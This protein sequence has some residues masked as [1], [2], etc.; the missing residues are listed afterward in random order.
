M[1][2]YFRNTQCENTS[3]IFCNYGSSVI[4]WGVPVC[5]L[6]IYADTGLKLQSTVQCQYPCQ[7]ISNSQDKKL[8]PP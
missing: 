8:V 4:Q 7:C 2:L 6:H 1:R 3:D 5:V